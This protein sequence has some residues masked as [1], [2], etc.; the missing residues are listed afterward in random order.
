[1]ISFVGL[2]KSPSEGRGRKGRHCRARRHEERHS[3]RGAS[4]ALHHQPSI[5]LLRKEQSLGHQN[6]GQDGVER[7]EFSNGRGIGGPANPSAK[8][9]RTQAA[10]V[11]QRTFSWREKP[12][13]D[14]STTYSLINPE[15][16]SSE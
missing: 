4:S 3:A 14:M 13:F 15:S 2:M 6:P 12:Q 5:W 9:N 10:G 1:M 7:N 11:A 8:L 16:L